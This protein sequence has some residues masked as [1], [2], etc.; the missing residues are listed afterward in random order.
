MKTQQTITIE[1]LL[2]QG[3]DSLTAIAQV[4]GISHGRVCQ[5]KQNMTKPTRAEMR[6]LWKVDEVLASNFKE[7]SQQWKWTVI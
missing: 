3:L 7:R 1:K 6:E 2:T 5:I 4:F